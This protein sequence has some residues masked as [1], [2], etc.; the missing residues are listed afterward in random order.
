MAAPRSERGGRGVPLSRWP[1]SRRAIRHTRR[2][3]PGPAAVGPRLARIVRRLAD[4]TRRVPA[5]AALTATD[6]A[7]GLLQAVKK[8]VRVTRKKCQ[9]QKMH[10]ILCKLPRLMHT[11]MNGPMHQLFLAPTCSAVLRR[12]SDLVAKFKNRD[13]RPWIGWR[14]ILVSQFRAPIEIE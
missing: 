9:V 13:P 8:S 6:G 5:R 14:A 4:L 10:N 2:L 12:G 7:P 11:K 3:S 1:V